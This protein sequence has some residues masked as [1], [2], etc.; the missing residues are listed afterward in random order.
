MIML[1]EL[2]HVRRRDTAINWLLV[3]VRAAHWWN[4]VFWLSAARFSTLREQACDAFVMRRLDQPRPR[5]YGELLLALAQ[6]Q[7]TNE[8]AVGTPSLDH[9]IHPIGIP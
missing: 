2:A 5:Q 1:H 8:L 6:R 4:P 7:R 9:G 3:F